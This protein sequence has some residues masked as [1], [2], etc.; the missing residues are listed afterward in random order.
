MRKLRAAL[1]LLTALALL[2]SG[3]SGKSSKEALKP[4]DEKEQ[5]K[6]KVMFWDQ[7]YFFQEYGNLFISKFPNLDIEVANMQSIYNSEADPTTAFE[8][9]VEENKPD[10]LMLFMDQLGSFAKAG[11]LYAL[12]PVIKQDNFDIA[13]IQPSVVNAL[14]EKGD[15]QL[16]GLSPTFGSKALFYNADLF[17]KYGV[18]PPRDSMSWEEVMALAKRFPTD[19]PEDERIYG[20][21]TETYDTLDRLVY[22][23]AATEKLRLLNAEGTQVMIDSDAWKKVLQTVVDAIRSKAIHLA[24]EEDRKKLQ[25]AL[26]MEDLYKMDMFLMGRSAMT[27]ASGGEIQS[28][29]QAKDQMKSVKPVNWQIVTAPVDPSNR[30]QSGSIDLYNIFAVNAASTNQRAAWEFVKF[31]N[32]EGYAKIKGKSGAFG[33]FLSRTTYMAEQ[34]GRSLEPFYKLDPQPAFSIFPERIPG[35][36]YGDY[37]QGMA[38]GLDAAIKGEKT[39]DEAVAAIKEELQQALTVARKADERKKAEQA[40]ASPSA[41]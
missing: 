16:Y 33:D 19:G 25:G 41:G 29:R 40:S 3:C 13:G 24:S 34:D 27:V 31:V 37:T 12:D 1:P 2:L 10:V 28:L 36:F 22:T 14:R 38:K 20:L 21:N 6:I 18:E 11:K 35:N 9:F 15:G 8:K 26:M 7:N 23:I 32:G 30:N 17:Q 39:L 4:L 5:A